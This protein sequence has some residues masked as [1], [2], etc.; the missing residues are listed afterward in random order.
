MR[1]GDAPDVF[2]DDLLVSFVPLTFPLPWRYAFCKRMQSPELFNN[3]ERQK[4]AQKSSGFIQHGSST[5]VIARGDCGMAEAVHNPDG[6]FQMKTTQYLPL[7]SISNVE[8][9]NEVPRYYGVL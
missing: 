7:G 5:K 3:L 2:A 1:R 8:E 6:N 4:G 9:M